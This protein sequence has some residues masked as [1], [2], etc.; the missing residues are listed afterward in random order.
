[1]DKFGGGIIL[2][3]RENSVKVIESLQY[4]TGLFSASRKDCTTG[5]NVAWIRD[6]VYTAMGMETFSIKK[7]VK[8]FQAL[9]DI[10]RRHEYKIDWAIK[11]KPRFAYQYIHARYHPITFDEFYD[12]WGNKQND[13][14]GAFLFKVGELEQRGIAV[15]RDE[16]D[17]LV[18]KKLV[19]YLQSI[20]YWH[21]PDHGMWEEGPEL[22]A[23]SIGACVAG[24]EKIK[25]IVAVP[26]ELI[27]KGR[28]AMNQ[29]LPR[30]SP[31]KSVDLAQLSLIFPYN[32]VTKEQAEQILKNVEE[33]LVR[34]KGVIRYHGDL[35][36]NAKGEAEWT[37][38][39]PWLASI[40][41]KLNMPNKYAFY[42]RKTTE[43]MNAK[44]ELPELYYGNSNLY[45]DNCPLGWAHAMHLLAMH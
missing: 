7:A 43:A 20:E 32:V 27:D 2:S 18:L 29:L 17:K 44:G 24:L 25:F 22:H 42:M 38:G 12:E 26:Q 3:Y 21:D 35:Y 40:Y 37:F 1:M 10:F 9:L 23:S 5:Y 8:T 33:Q 36:Y 34:N 6:N 14:I 45:N 16:H 13:A 30:E 28:E 31:T 11:D 15:I 41:K 4:P 19:D 39:F